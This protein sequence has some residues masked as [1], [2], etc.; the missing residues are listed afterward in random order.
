MS[1]ILKNFC[2]K[3]KENKLTVLLESI[4]RTFLTFKVSINII[5]CG[6]TGNNS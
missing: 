5:K 6:I 1:K 4:V 3:E 2:K